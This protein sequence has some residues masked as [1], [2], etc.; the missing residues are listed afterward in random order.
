MRRIWIVAVVL[1]APLTATAGE[2]GVQIKRD[3]NHIDFIAGGELVARYQIG[4]KFPRPIFWPLLAPNGAKVTRSWPMDENV[5]GESKDHI[6]QKSAWFCHGDVI[7]EGMELKHKIRGVD[8][9]DFWSEAKGHG[10]I[11]LTK[12]GKPKIAGN[13]ATLETHNEWQTADGEKIMDEERKISFYDFGKARLIVLDVDLHASVCPI[14][15]GDTKEGALGIRVNDQIRGDKKADASDVPARNKAIRDGLRAVANRGADLCNKQNDWD[16]CCRVYQGALLALTP[17]L[18]NRPELQKTIQDGV[19]KANQ[20]ADA[21]QRAFAL[22]KLIDQARGPIAPSLPGWVEMTTGRIQNAEGKINEKGC[23]GQM[24]DW[25]DYSG[26]I[27]GKVAGI[28]VLA[29]PKNAQPTCWHSRNYGLMA[30]NPFGRKRA[31]FPAVKG[32]TDLVR[33]AKGEHLR[34]RYGILV[35]EGDAE[36]G[37]VAELY[38]RF[39]KLGE[40]P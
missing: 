39:V 29:D 8:G 26:P 12:I 27:D 13:K 10:R 24:S 19:A 15:F 7:P 40:Q 35:H 16:G 5:P 6:H 20:E 36:T 2:A 17:F 32:R 25:C 21:V 31:A 23:W 33:L 14:T 3:K 28:A 37:R 9:V 18:A 30:A 1:L 38:Q 11:V 34:L 4:P 22:R